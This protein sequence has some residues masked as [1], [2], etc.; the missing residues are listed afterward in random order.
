MKT[1]FLLLLLAAAVVS[2]HAQTQT[3][4]TQLFIDPVAWRVA[5]TS[6][7]Q[8]DPGSDATSAQQQGQNAP[9]AR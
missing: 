8:S 6:A 9:E 5:E 3:P 4:Q 1:A 2:A 7:V